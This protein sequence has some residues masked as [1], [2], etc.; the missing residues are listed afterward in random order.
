MQRPA[1]PIERKVWDGGVTGTPLGLLAW[2][3]VTFIPSWREA[4][5]AELETL[6]PLAVGLGS[7]I[8]AAYRAPHTFRVDVPPPELARSLP[9]PVAPASITHPGGEDS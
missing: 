8:Y 9:A 3:L 4:I 7:A 2:A 1:G 6:I 5:P